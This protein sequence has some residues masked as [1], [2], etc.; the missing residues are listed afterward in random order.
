MVSA[1]SRVPSVVK[2][3]SSSAIQRCHNSALPAKAASRT[4]PRARRRAAGASTQT[5]YARRPTVSRRVHVTPSSSTVGA[6]G[7]V[8]QPPSDE[9]YQSVQSLTW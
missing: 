2:N 4:R 8:F 7:R 9:P 3:A 6:H 1:R 5:A